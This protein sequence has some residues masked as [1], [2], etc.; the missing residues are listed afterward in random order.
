MFGSPTR[1]FESDIPSNVIMK[2]VECNFKN[3]KI[4]NFTLPTSMYL[5]ELRF[6]IR[7]LNLTILVDMKWTHFI[8]FFFYN[9]FFLQ[10]QA[11]ISMI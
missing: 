7:K 10:T 2:S 3:C 9:I 1:L 5:F 11:K 8:P 6:Y 4:R